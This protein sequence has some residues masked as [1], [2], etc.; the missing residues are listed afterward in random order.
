MLWM[1]NLRFQSPAKSSRERRATALRI[2]SYRLQLKLSKRKFA[3][4]QNL[5]RRSVPRI[6][7]LYASTNQ[8]E[9][10]SFHQD[11]ILNRP[12][13]QNLKRKTGCSLSI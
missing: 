7:N 12:K 5:S 2:N 9:G 8:A 13:A 10:T 4:K 1:T 11:Q 6:G 3:L